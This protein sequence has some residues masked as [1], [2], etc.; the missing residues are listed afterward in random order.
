MLLAPEALGVDLVDVLG[1]RGARGEPAVRGR[2]LE[3]PDRR[4]VSRRAREL[5]DDRVAGQFRGGHL[6]RGEPRER[7]AL[8]LRGRGVDARVPGAAVLALQG[9]VALAGVLAV[10]RRDL[11]REQVHDEAVLVGDPDRAVAAQEGGAGALLAGEGAGAREQPVDEPLEA[12][13]RLGDAAAETR[14]DAVDHRAGDERLAD[15]WPPPAS[16]AGARRGARPRRRD[17]GSG[18]SGRR[19]G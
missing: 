11:G 17:S 8:G 12:D 1:A 19:C 7:V 2:D 10:H 16:A 3:P 14:G 5:R 15:R 18:S 13:R 6:G 9:A 4:V